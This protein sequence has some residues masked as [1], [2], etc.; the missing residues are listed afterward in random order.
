[1]VYNFLRGDRDQP[2][3]LPPDLR[4][5]LP[6]DPAGRAGGTRPPSQ[7]L[8]RRPPEPRSRRG[9]SHRGGRRPPGGSGHRDAPRPEKP[10]TTCTLRLCATGSDRSE[11]ERLWAR[12]DEDG[13][14]HPPVCVLRASGADLSTTLERSGRPGRYPQAS[15]GHGLTRST[16]NESVSA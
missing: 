16:S 13:E 10:L 12:I 5:W 8:A 14:H 9:R 15:I 3:L 11:L 4:D 2:F 7:W 6:Q 1:M